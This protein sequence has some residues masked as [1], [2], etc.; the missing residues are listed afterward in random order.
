MRISYIFP[1]YSPVRISLVL[2][3]ESALRVHPP[4]GTFLL[5]YVPAIGFTYTTNGASLDLVPL[6]RS[7]D[8]NFYEAMRKNSFAYVVSACRAPRI[9]GLSAPSW[10]SWTPWSMVRVQGVMLP[11][12]M[13]L[14]RT[15]GWSGGNAIKRFLSLIGHRANKDFKAEFPMA[16][17][18]TYADSVHH[19]HVHVYTFQLK[20]PKFKYDVAPGK[21]K[22]TKAAKTMLTYVLRDHVLDFFR[23][24]Y[25]PKASIEVSPPRMSDHHFPF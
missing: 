7:A 10:P 24:W 9:T 1:S 11:S 22:S 23:H 17:C 5:D 18:F 6:S 13:E 20:V 15:C 3:K 4:C 2:R 16:W 8:P 14:I 21:E 25:E 12:D 19:G